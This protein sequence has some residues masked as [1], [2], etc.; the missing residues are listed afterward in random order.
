L[1]K[2]KIYSLGIM[3][4]VE[5]KGLAEILQDR[6]DQGRHPGYQL[7]VNSE[8]DEAIRYQVAACPCGTLSVSKTGH[9]ADRLI[10]YS[11]FRQTILHSLFN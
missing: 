2:D 3:T 11:I 7:D 5:L 6:I 8:P 4:L 1:S 10:I 9:T